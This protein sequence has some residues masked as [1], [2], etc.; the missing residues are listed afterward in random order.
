MPETLE[1]N[2]DIKFDKVRLTQGTIY[3]NGHKLEIGDEVTSD[4]RLTVY[5]GGNGKPI[6]G[7]TNIELYGGKYDR[8]GRRKDLWNREHKCFGGNNRC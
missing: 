3:A 5:G 4:D 6:N 2:S 8:T 7:D 1:C